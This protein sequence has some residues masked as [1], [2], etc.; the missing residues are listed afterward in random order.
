MDKPEKPAVAMYA[1]SVQHVMDDLV[2]YES[3]TQ[4]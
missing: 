2:N 4:N 3:V 1:N